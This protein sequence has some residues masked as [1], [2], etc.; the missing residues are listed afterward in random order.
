MPQ[1]VLLLFLLLALARPAD[2]AAP[3]PEDYNTSLDLPAAADGGADSVAL[4]LDD[5]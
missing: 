5:Q 4:P 1:F 2:A 3:A